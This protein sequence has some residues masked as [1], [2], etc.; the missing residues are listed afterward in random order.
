MEERIAALEIGAQYDA[1]QKEVQ[2]VQMECLQLLRDVKQ[3]LVTGGD[4]SSAAVG[5]A[6]A[7]STQQVEALQAQIIELQ[8]Q[9]AKKDYR[10]EHLVNV[11]ETLLT[12][13]KATTTTTSS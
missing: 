9:A 1:N 3:S 13:R 4:D 2:R 5:V 11:V 8:K 10:I 12:E 6:A 7:A